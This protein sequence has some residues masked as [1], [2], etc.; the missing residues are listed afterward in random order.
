VLTIG[1]LPAHAYSQLTHEELI[2]LLWA[3]SIRPLLVARY[4]QASEAALRRAHAYSYGGCLIQDI[5]YYPFGKGFFSDLAH[6]VRSGDFVGRMLRDAR[7]VDEFAFAI[8]ALSHY[9]GDAIGHGEG[10]NPATALTFPDLE[11]KYGSFVTF[12]QAPTA[13]GRTEFGFD[14]AQT[15][16]HRYA[17]RAYRKKIGFRVARQLLYR[18]FQETY[19]I[20]ARGILGPARSAL[21]SYRWSVTRLLPA[22]LHAQIV[23]LSSR[24]PVENQSE[25]RTEFL[26]RIS[27]AEYAATARNTYS[28]P[29]IR[30]RLLAVLILIIPKVGRLKVL[31]VRAPTAD[32]EELFLRSIDHAIDSFR[33]IL[34]RMR[35]NPGEDLRLPNLNLDTGKEVVP[36]EAEVVDRAFD[37]LVVRIADEKI[38][39]PPDLRKLLLSHYADPAHPPHAN[40]DLK[41]RQRV[42]HA[43]EVLR[44]GGDRGFNPGPVD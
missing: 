39:I 4:P 37:D 21:P 6:Y 5:G 36:G 16:W 34:A 11:S 26:V 22:F 10:I 20:R 3:D 1:S 9:V 43:I 33:E 40:D 28:K 15:A 24:L 13:H 8:G 38:V 23:L 18:A 14:V 31:A 27:H 41:E 17:S 44:A 29:G 30:A 25:A 19:G 7:N 42:T 32:T 2:D 35:A 12:E